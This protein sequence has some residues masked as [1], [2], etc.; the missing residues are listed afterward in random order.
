MRKHLYEDLC[1]IHPNL[2]DKIDSPLLRYT[3]MIL[4]RVLF[5]GFAERRGLLKRDLLSDAI[6]Q[7]E[8]FN[9]Q[10]LWANVRN[11]FK[12]IDKGWQRE[13]IHAYNGGL[14]RDNP[15]LNEL[16]VSDQICQRFG[17]LLRFDY[18]DDVSVEVLGHIF[19]QSISDLEAMRA[20]KGDADDKPKKDERRKKRAFFIRR[21][22]SHA[23][24]CRKLW[25]KR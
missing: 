23:L 24:L 19:E 10:P 17:A 7:V 15:E 20:Q 6:R 21:R 22:T 9:P 5:I 8:R 2:A 4:D 12:W 18:A 16:E 14:F 25:A 11:V 3:Q 13:G 1:R